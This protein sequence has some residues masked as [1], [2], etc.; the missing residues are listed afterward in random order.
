M[1]NESAKLVTMLVISL[2]SAGVLA[3]ILRSFFRRIRRIEEDR[4]GK[5]PWAGDK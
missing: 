5:K 2:A 3:M 1:E 4:W